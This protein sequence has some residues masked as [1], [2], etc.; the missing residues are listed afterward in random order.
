M[1]GTISF[2]AKELFL[3]GIYHAAGWCGWCHRFTPDLVKFYD[4]VRTTH[5]DLQLVYLS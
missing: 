3:Y 1:P 2:Q 5:P 4:E